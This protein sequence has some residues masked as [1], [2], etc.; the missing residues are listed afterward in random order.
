MVDFD[1]SVIGPFTQAFGPFVTCS[2]AAGAPVTRTAVR[3]QP[4]KEIDVAPDC[5]ARYERG[6]GVLGRE[7]WRC[8]SSEGS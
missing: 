4:E 6:F 2:P 7:L 1:T 5:G 3:G 8:V